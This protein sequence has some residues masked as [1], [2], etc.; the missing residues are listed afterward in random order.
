MR[1][2]IAASTVLVVALG[3]PGT[4]LACPGDG[5]AAQAS[6]R[7]LTAYERQSWGNPARLALVTSYLGIPKAQ[8]VDRLKSGQT[9]A[10]VANATPGK[11][12]TGL[13]DYVV[14]RA[15]TRL[16][17]AVARGLIDASQEQ[18]ML[19]RLTTSVTALVNGTLLRGRHLR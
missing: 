15:K 16:D 14:A 2:R 11:S 5:G 13:V 7:I 9:L 12:A 10:Q 19:T 8:I 1:R 18:T 17:A 6:T 3:A 4:A